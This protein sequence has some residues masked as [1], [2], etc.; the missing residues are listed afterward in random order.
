[1][2]DFKNGQTATM[3]IPKDSGREIGFSILLSYAFDYDLDFIMEQI[4]ENSGDQQENQNTISYKGNNYLSH[5]IIELEHYNDLSADPKW[6]K[7]INRFIERETKKNVDIDW[8]I[9]TLNSALNFCSDGITIGIEYQYVDKVYRDSYYTHIGGEHFNKSRFCKRLV[10]FNGEVQQQLSNISETILQE[11]FIGSIVIRPTKEKAIGR[12]LLNPYYFRSSANEEVNIR[13]SKYN[14][15]FSGMKL[16][17]EAFPFEMQDGITTTCAEITLLNLLDYYSNEFQ[18]YQFILPSALKQIIKKLSTDRVTPATGISYG[19]ISKVLYQTGFTPKFYHDKNN[20]KTTEIIQMLSFYV[21]SGIPVAIGMNQDERKRSKGH[22][23]IC[24]GHGRSSNKQILNFVKNNT[25][26]NDEIKE[27][28][29]N[30]KKRSENESRKASLKRQTV[31]F[32]EMENG[33]PKILHRVFS[34]VAIDQFIIQDDLNRPYN[35]MKPDIENGT[36]AEAVA[37]E[38]DLDKKWYVS[39]IVAPLYKRMHID[40][41]QARGIIDQILMSKLGPINKGI[42]VENCIVVRLFLASSKNLQ[43]HRV[44][45][46]SNI[47]VRNLY[48]FTPFP[49][50]V[51]VAELYDIEKYPDENAFGEIILDATNAEGVGLESVV[52]VNYNSRHLARDRDGTNITQEN[53][54]NAASF[55]FGVFWGENECTYKPYNHNLTVFSDKKQKQET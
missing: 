4:G 14:I 55:D 34:Y 11:N 43:N 16:Y 30:D 48:R 27:F 21:E 2:E 9:Q 46:T 29:A 31:V 36:L 26:D 49:K 35:I 15:T 37:S 22:S 39:C 24:I 53:V 19:G 12:C 17:V 13:V 41:K 44:K 45:S 38:T 47:D 1:M 52:M 32:R 18:D 8:I 42:K 28:I 51:W 10:L 33:E 7:A 5:E 40:A 3:F 54:K 23:V 6:A 20:I 25:P 50:F